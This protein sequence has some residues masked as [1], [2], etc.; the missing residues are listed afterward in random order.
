M[1]VVTL[2]KVPAAA[3]VVVGDGGAEVVAF[4]GWPKTGGRFD[5]KR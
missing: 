2:F 4:A 3:L 5:R 1:V